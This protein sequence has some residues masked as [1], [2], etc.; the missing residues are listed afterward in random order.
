[1][2]DPKHVQLVSLKSDKSDCLISQA[3]ALHE[4]MC[5]GTMLFLSHK[6]ANLVKDAFS[7]SPKALVRTLFLK[8]S[9]SVL[10]KQF[11]KVFFVNEMQK[12]CREEAANTL[13]FHRADL[14]FDGA[15]TRDMERII[16]DIADVAHYYHKKVIF[17]INDSNRL[18]QTLDELLQ[19]AA[20]ICYGVSQYNGKCQLQVLKQKKEDVNIV[21][22]SDSKE[23]VSFHE[24]L[25]KKDSHIRF[26]HIAK[27]DSRAQ[28]LL[29]EAD[30]IV[31]NIENIG[32][33]EQ[34]LKV[35][36]TQKLKT[37]FFYLSNDKVIRKRDKIDKLEKGVTHVYEKDFDML[38][39]IYDIEKS[40]G[41]AFY[42]NILQQVNIAPKNRYITDVEKFKTI[43]Y[44]YSN[45]HI[46]FSVTAVEY[47][48]ETPMD[49]SLIES[50]IRDQDIVYHDSNN[51]HVM[52]MMLDTL[53]RL[54]KQIIESRLE[55]KQIAIKALQTYDVHACQSMIGYAKEADE[56]ATLK[57]YAKGE[58]A[59]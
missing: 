34:L 5:D 36:G 54:S 27:L 31:Y 52:F 30:C 19:D 3:I 10:D 59:V 57:S 33:K 37:K 9:W 46:Y 2:N 53:P 26:D 25:F 35:I 42:S 18:G 47:S 50:C 24:Y 45:F 49:Q 39:Y 56:K 17:G 1:M 15:S 58:K 40:V 29:E 38:E 44:N 32:L 51:R 8:D 13:Y 11:G 6:D 48:A 21:L 16:S 55:A 23:M 4:K 41:R 43:L 20:D 7:S 28:K 14:F 12:M 22:F